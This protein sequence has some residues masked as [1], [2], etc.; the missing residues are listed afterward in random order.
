M[1]RKS[2]KKAG[3]IE[4]SIHELKAEFVCLKVCVCLREG[5]RKNSF[6]ITA[7]IVKASNPLFKKDFKSAELLT[8]TFFFL[9]FRDRPRM[10]NEAK[11]CRKY[12]HKTY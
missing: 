8:K 1:G 3:A 9:Y 6:G 4:K 11:E 7:I 10:T 5:E 2:R 12:K